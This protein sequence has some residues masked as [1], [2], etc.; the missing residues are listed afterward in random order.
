MMIIST[1]PQS[2]TKT[3]SCLNMAAQEWQTRGMKEMNHFIY[4]PRQ[5]STRTCVT[6]A[7]HLISGT[8]NFPIQKTRWWARKQLPSN[9]QN[10]MMLWL[11]FPFPSLHDLI[12]AHPFL[13]LLSGLHSGPGAYHNLIPGVCHCLLYLLLL[14]KHLHFRP[15]SRWAF[16]LKISGWYFFCK[17][18]VYLY[19]CNSFFFPTKEDWAMQEKKHYASY[20]CFR[21]TR[22]VFVTKLWLHN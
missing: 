4:Y 20:Q 11:P 2:I 7:S 15:S 21:I 8:V 19:I 14:T 12:P 22:L 3:P 17:W 6:L 9:Y 1:C 5:S 16:S 13:L 18:G 10:P